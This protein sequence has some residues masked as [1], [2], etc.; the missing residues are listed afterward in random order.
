L[1]ER[2]FKPDAGDNLS[3]SK[4]KIGLY[5]LEFVNKEN[6]KL[7]DIKLINYFNLLIQNING[8]EFKVKKEKIDTSNKFYFWLFAV[9]CG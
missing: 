6:S 5:S 2:I 9:L 3:V 4:R 1:N 8:K 7:T